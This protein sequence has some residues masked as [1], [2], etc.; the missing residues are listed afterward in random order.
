MKV[1]DLVARR[2]PAPDGKLARRIGV[3]IEK[4]PQERNKSFVLVKWCDPYRI[5][6]KL[7]TEELEVISEG[8]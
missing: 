2:W 8:R 5:V 7:R 1:G 6:E 4:K 3:V